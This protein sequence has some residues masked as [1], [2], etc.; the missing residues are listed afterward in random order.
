M[1]RSSLTQE[2]VVYTGHSRERKVEMGGFLVQKE[3]KRMGRKCREREGET[4]G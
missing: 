3:R 4:D 2:N 1:E